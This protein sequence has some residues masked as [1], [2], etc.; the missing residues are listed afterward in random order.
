MNRAQAYLARILALAVVCMFLVAC[1]CDS[2][3]R[4]SPRLGSLYIATLDEDGSPTSW[5][6]AGSI[7]NLLEDRY[8]T[9]STDP[10]TESSSGMSVDLGVEDTQAFTFGLTGTSDEK[11]YIGSVSNELRQSLYKPGVTD[12]QYGRVAT[13]SF[14][15][16]DLARRY[17]AVNT[18]SP[19]LDSN[20]R[21]NERLY[22]CN[23][24][25][26]TNLYQAS[27]DAYVGFGAEQMVNASRLNA[28]GHWSEVHWWIADDARAISQAEWDKLAED[29][30]RNVIGKKWVVVQQ[31]L[32]PWDIQHLKV[33]LVDC[34]T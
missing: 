1:T 3:K 33:E 7:A 22:V 2:T 25:L 29:A 21:P 18:S 9:I 27:R 24:V 5:R 34:N 16:D 14:G 23:Q 30:K 19:T 28:N 4:L 31:A 13:S 6:A 17:F 32:V 26:S 12:P 10:V 8:V 20:I 15:T 11:L